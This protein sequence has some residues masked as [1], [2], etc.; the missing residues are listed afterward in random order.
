MMFE[1]RLLAR[2]TGLKPFFMFELSL[3]CPEDLS[4]ALEALDALSVGRGR[5][6]PDRRRAGPVW[7]ARHATAQRSA[8]SAPRGGAVPAGR[9]GRVKRPSCCRQDFFEG[10]QVLGVAAVPEQDWV[11]LTQSQFAP[12]EITPEFLDRAHL[13]RAA[14]CRPQRSDPAGPGPGLWHRHTPHH[15]HVPALDRAHNLAGGLGACAGLRLWLRHSGHRCCQVRCAGQ[16]DAVD[17]DPAAVESTRANAEANRRAAAR[18]PAGAGAGRATR[19]CWP[20][21]WPRR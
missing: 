20:T 17:I 4:D 3:M 21:S 11:R 14:R 15:P 19:R 5:R 8:G 2:R 9:S 18:R 7:R 6:R 13:A 1:L 12:V 16:V 10:C